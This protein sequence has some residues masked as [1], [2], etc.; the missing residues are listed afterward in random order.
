MRN[1]IP[2]HLLP[3]LA[4]LFAAPGVSAVDHVVFVNDGNF[5]PRDVMIDP[6]D[7]V[8][9][10]AFGNAGS[11]N[12]HADDDS[13]RC[14]KGCRGTNGASGDPAKE[15]T[16]TLTFTTPGVIGFRCDPHGPFGMTGS[17]TVSAVAAAGQSVVAGLSGNWYD[18]SSNQGGHGF[19]VEILPNNGMLVIWFVFN[20][21]GTQQNWIYAQG[22]Y[23]PA[24]N[25][26]MLPAFLEQGGAFPPNFDSSKL[27]LAR[28]GFLTFTF[29]DC[30]SGSVAW[31]SNAASAAA[32]YADVTFPIQH[33]TSIAGTTCP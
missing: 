15:W 27:S 11:H 32:G 31:K 1:P 14:G 23:D 33:L 8:T 22:S 4:L 7:T 28:W 2:K 17:I 24:S 25:T 26:V 19:Q 21:A 9:F 12:V 16:D 30:G 5:E 29:N 6:G 18:P 10:K 13:F 3:L 20:P